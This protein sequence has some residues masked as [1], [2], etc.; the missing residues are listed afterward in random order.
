M[1]GVAGVFS[2]VDLGSRK[3]ASD[4]S[5]AAALL[6]HRGPDQKAISYG[7]KHVLINT[8]LKVQDLSAAADLPFQLP[9]YGLSLAYN[10]EVSNFEELVQSFGLASKYGLR[11]KSDTEVLALLYVE[12]GIEFLQQLTGMF[13]LAIVDQRRQK[14]FLVRDF[15][16]I[17]PLYY[18]SRAGE[19][20]F[21]SELKVLRHWNQGQV[22]VNRQAIFDLLTLGYIPQTQTP[23]QEILELDKGHL[24]EFDLTTG[25]HEVKKYYQLHYR[26]DT[27]IGE[28]QAAS[29][30]H[31][32]MADSVR[33]NMI[34]D[35]PLG[36]T[37]SGGIDTSA[38]LGLAHEMGRS[39][40][41]HTFSIKVDESSFDES[42]FQRQ[43][44][45]KT[46][47]THHEILFTAKHVSENIVQ[48]IAF[49]DEP[50]AN[51]ATLPSFVLSREAAS[52]V[53]VLLSGEGGDEIFNAYDTHLAF[54]V[55]E[56]YLR[57]PTFIRQAIRRGVAGLPTRHNKLSFDFRA[58]RFVEGSELPTASA[59]I[60]W[61]HGFREANIRS[62]MFGGEG[63]RSTYDL[64]E[65]ILGRQ[66]G[67]EGLNGVSFLDLDQYLYGDL[68]V[69]ND[70]MMM[71]HSVESRFPLL[72]RPLVEYMTT[73]PRNLRIKGWRP[74]Y[75][76]KRAMKNVLPREILKRS[77]FG[78]EMPHSKWLLGPLRHLVE[79]HLSHNAVQ[80]AA[81][82]D[83][84]VVRKM[85]HE[86]ESGTVD[87]GRGLWT[88][89]SCQIWHRLFVG[90]SD[91]LKYFRL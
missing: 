31:Q 21:A 78:L 83:P 13:S 62:L 84:V 27:N 22:S 10:G 86:H 8:R 53:K 61:R 51:G 1:C 34:S 43:M 23:Y 89:I 90:S 29:K 64:F 55:R 20:Q 19:L 42:R 60:F 73:V 52:H 56:L 68:M 70:R 54:K 88:L 59:H 45:A 65:D 17:T 57:L 81:L 36:M 87:H 5:A 12:L 72:D 58:K 33:R 79:E 75:I 91:Y 49:L 82:F 16:G 74:R 77:S 38:I 63:L 4:W 9:D 35:A 30:I 39:Q 26:E 25:H 69:K 71:A 76:E 7:Q 67:I 44:S 47:S 40:G 28:A 37:L 14:A 6:H 11:T 46:G 50:S 41:L 32:L 80:E 66:A 2:G 15:F 48:H 3:L 18:R 85:W 24:I